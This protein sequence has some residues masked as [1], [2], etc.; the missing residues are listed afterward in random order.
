MHLGPFR[1]SVGGRRITLSPA[2]NTIVA[3][4]EEGVPR[5]DRAGIAQQEAGV[6]P[7]LTRFEVPAEKFTIYPFSPPLGGK[8]ISATTAI[9]RLDSSPSVVRAAQVYQL[10]DKQVVA[11]DRIL[12]RFG[13]GQSY[14]VQTLEV[15]GFEYLAEI[16]GTFVFRLPSTEDPLDVA[17]RL[18]TLDWVQYA[19]PDLV[20]IGGRPRVVATGGVQGLQASRQQYAITI[21]QTDLAW[22]T[23]SGMPSIKI[24]ILDDGVDTTHPSLAG[25]IVDA[26]DAIYNRSG[27][28][29]NPWDTHGTACAGIAAAKSGVTGDLRGVAGGCSILAIRIAQSPA[30]GQRWATANSYIAS[31]I[32]WAVRRGVDVLSCSWGG[33]APSS[34]IVEALGRAR[35]EGR[36]G[37]GCVIVAAAGN[38]SANVEF[39]G[40]VIGVLAVSGTNEFDEFKTPYTHDGENWWGSN[41]GPEV[42]VAAPS[43]HIYTA[44]V[45]GPGGDAPGDFATSFN[46]TS[47]ATPFVAG[48]AALILSA[49]SSLSESDVRRVIRESADRVGQYPYAAQRNDYLGYGRLNV[50]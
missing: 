27:S 28:L 34:A 23:R 41:F 44:D 18:A 11:T 16:D 4:Y 3:R 15:M 24:A 25:S 47:A 13:R 10:G 33:G 12:V 36:G 37:K 14:R 6:G 8:G 19:E 1:Y 5:G 46:G 7:I 32:D 49:K 21:T 38:D 45:V 35:Q 17:N 50:R 20:T 31:G 42:D 29:P 9:T 26:Y 39:P 30:R 22:N 2:K 48:A 40:N 43:V